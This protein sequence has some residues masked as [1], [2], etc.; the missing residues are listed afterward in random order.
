MKVI[1]QRRWAFIKLYE[2]GERPANIFHSLYY[3]NVTRDFV[4]R[5]IKRYAETG[6]TKDMKRCRRQRSARTKKMLC[7]LKARIKGYHGRSQHR[8]VKEMNVSQSSFQRA[9]KKNLNLKPFK[10]IK[11]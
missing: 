11:S 6:S 1:E 5:T 10:K 2:N 9:L 3:L 8:L 7:S 4:S